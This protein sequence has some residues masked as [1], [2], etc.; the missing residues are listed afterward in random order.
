MT[1]GASRKGTRGP[2]ATPPYKAGAELDAVISAANSNE[3][4]HERLNRIY[5]FV[6]HAV[7]T[8][9]E[10]FAARTTVWVKAGVA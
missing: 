1:Q 6:Y 9:P 3:Y 2:E 7:R 8:D 10:E 4:A 5:A